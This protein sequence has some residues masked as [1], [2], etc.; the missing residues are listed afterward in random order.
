M[1]CLTIPTDDMRIASY[2]HDTNASISSGLA[3]H[4]EETEDSLRQDKVLNRASSNS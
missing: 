3:N 4:I 1:N 2:C